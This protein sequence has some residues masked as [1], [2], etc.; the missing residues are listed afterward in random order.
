MEMNSKT[1]VAFLTILFILIDGSHQ[2]EIRSCE[3]LEMMF[4]SCM[5]WCL[6]NPL[7]VCNCGKIEND[8]KVCKV[9]KVDS[10]P[11]VNIPQLHEEQSDQEQSGYLKPGRGVNVHDDYSK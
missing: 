3:N 6:Q 1:F 7:Q 10:N 8:L 11:M 9:Q 4:I 2:F 5:D